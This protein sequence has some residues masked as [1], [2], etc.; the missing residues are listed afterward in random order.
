MRVPEIELL[1]WKGCPSTERALAEL[2]TALQET[3]LSEAHIAM[4][5]I[6]DEDL[7]RERGF[8]GSPTVLVDG[9]DVAPAGDEEAGLNCRIYRLRNGKVSP[10]PDPQDLRDALRRALELEEVRR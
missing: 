4:S 7:A 10:T 5:E 9:R 3:G 2:R 8:V 6:G 1:W